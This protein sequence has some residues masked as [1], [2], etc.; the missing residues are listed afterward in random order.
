MTGAATWDAM[1]SLFASVFTQPSSLLF[2]ELLCGWVLCPGRRTVTGMIGL[3]ETPARRAH[4]AYHRFLRAGAWT[5]EHLWALLA[6]F[7]VSTLL[8]SG[9]VLQFDL[10]D[11]LFHKTGRKVDG[12]GIFRD[13]VRS[14]KTRVVYALGLNVVVLTLR[15]RAIASKCVAVPHGYDPVYRCPMWN[16]AISHSAGH[17]P[18][19]SSSGI[20]VDLDAMALPCASCHRGVASRSACRSTSGCTARAVPR[21]WTWPRR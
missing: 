17:C 19:V 20:H 2:S 10:D 3:A 12:A 4:D 16:V 1:L 5:M 18:P 6:A 7:L 15:I 21:I 8:P 14:T 9:A 13:A 11:T